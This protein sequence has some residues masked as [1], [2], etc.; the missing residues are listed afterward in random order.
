[1][2]Q[3]VVGGAEQR[4]AGVAADIAGAVDHR[5]RMLDAHADRRTASAST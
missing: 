4:V 3:L 5:L 2:H 1:M